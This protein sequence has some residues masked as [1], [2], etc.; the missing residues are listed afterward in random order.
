MFFL[1]FFF[2][3]RNRL[4]GEGTLIFQHCNETMIIVTV[5]SCGPSNFS[6]TSAQPP[7]V[8]VLS[9]SQSIGIKTTEPDQLEH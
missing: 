7:V 6:P 9:M 2:K 1:C 3:F 5:F 4:F 8:F